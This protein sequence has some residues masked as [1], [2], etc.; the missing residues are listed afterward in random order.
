MSESPRFPSARLRRAACLR[1]AAAAAAWLLAGAAGATDWVAV[2][3]LDAA[4]PD[5][6][7]AVAP[8][9]LAAAAGGPL[10]AKVVVLPN[11][12]SFFEKFG[13][14]AADPGAATALVGY[15][16]DP[17]GRGA[18][19][20]RL[21]AVDLA[22]GRVVR[23]A[24]APGLW[25]PLAVDAAGDGA[26]GGAGDPR[27]LVRSADFGIGKEARLEVWTVGRRDVARGRSWV[28][29]ESA[30]GRFDGDVSWAALADGG[31]AVTLSDDGRLAAW[32]LTAGGPQATGAPP[33]LWRLDLGRGEQ[34][35]ALSPSGS[36]LAVL[37]DGA[38]LLIDLAAG[39]TAAAIPGIDGYFF[40]RLA[41]ARD[42]A[43]LALLNGRALRVFDLADGSLDT[44]AVLPEAPGW[45]GAPGAVGG[46]AVAWVGPRCVLIGG[47][48]LVDVESRLPLWRYRA[49]APPAVAGGVAWF[50]LAETG[51]GKRAALAGYALPHP[52]A[53]AALERAK[54][55]PDFLVSEAGD[56]VRVDASAVP[57]DGRE[58]AR[59][60]LEKP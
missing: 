53:A 40:P 47:E 18:G 1:P 44:A 8:A 36:H 55:D 49:Q 26:A 9:D 58:K 3:V 16:L 59:A 50:P 5:G 30:E 37:A 39:K 56:R 29:Y 2:P 13:G 51:A 38:V 10:D 46:G 25:V 11:R 57:A 19:T 21:A 20:T 45:S 28:P 60:G 6:P 15:T 41:F 14:V 27:A 43:R 48:L 22:R 42:G 24:T 17:P 54:T 35:P 7:W 33:A 23:E 12:E 52:E 32:D 4:P 34:T 31:R